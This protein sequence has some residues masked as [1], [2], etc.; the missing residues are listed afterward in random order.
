[1]VNHLSYPRPLND[2]LYSLISALSYDENGNARHMLFMTEWG[3]SLS[4]FNST[5][6]V[7]QLLSS[8]VMFSGMHAYYLL[9]VRYVSLS[10]LR[11]LSFYCPNWDAVIRATVGH[12]NQ[13]PLGRLPGLL[14]TIQLYRWNAARLTMPF[15]WSEG[16]CDGV[17]LWQLVDHVSCSGLTREINYNAEARVQIQNFL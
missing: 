5:F 8:L 14:L 9:S 3:N 10:A 7:M 1:M 16:S 6:S 17:T 15:S 4:L 2:S 11:P 13:L 12:A